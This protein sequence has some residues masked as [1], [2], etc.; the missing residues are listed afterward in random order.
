MLAMIVP[1]PP[2]TTRR[3]G[4]RVDLFEGESGCTELGRR[5]QRV[6]QRSPRATIISNAVGNHASTMG[7][8]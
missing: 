6:R 3:Y 2:I 8:S 4:S 1:E 5:I 7:F